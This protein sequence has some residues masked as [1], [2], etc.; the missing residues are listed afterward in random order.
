MFFAA[1]RDAKPT[2]KVHFIPK[3]YETDCSNFSPEAYHERCPQLVSKY[4]TCHR[5]CGFCCIDLSV[6]GV[7]HSAQH[8]QVETLLG[9]SNS[10][11]NCD[12]HKFAIGHDHVLTREADITEPVV[13]TGTSGKPASNSHCLPFTPTESP[14]NLCVRSLAF[15]STVVAAPSDTTRG[16]APPKGSSAI[17]R[18]SI[19]SVRGGPG[20]RLAPTAQR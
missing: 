14:P 2:L 10:R 18:T 4:R 8:K 19:C 15:I 20:D 12:P 16:G 3:M 11:K 6:N 1:L 7:F 9:Y 17:R 13:P 5:G